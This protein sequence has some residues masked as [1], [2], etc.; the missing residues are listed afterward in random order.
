MSKS[1]FLLH[2]IQPVR[3]LRLL[4]LFI[5]L[6]MAM[7]ATA[8][9]AQ[10]WQPVPDIDLSKYSP[11]DFSDAEVDMPYFLK[12]FHTIANSVVQSGPA[13]GFINI[14]VWRAKKT[15]QTY[16]ARIMENVIALAYFYSTKRPWNPYY[17]SEPVR[18]RLE[19]AL[20]NLANSQS[21]QGHFAEYGQDKWNLSATAFYT[22][23]MGQTIKMIKD[24]PQITP[25]VLKRAIE[26][27]RK[28]I[29]L[30]LNDD[31][32]YQS[33]MVFANQYGNVWGGALAY[34]SMFPDKAME[35]QM[36]VRL[37]QAKEFQSPIGFF[38]EG[39]ATDFGYNLGTHQSDLWSAYQYSRGT[40]L[41]K[42]FVKE[43]DNFGEWIKY[44]AVPEPGTDI[45]TLNRGIETRQKAPVISDSFTFRSTPLSL[46][47]E[48]IRAFVFS[49][50]DIEKKAKKER[51]KLKT[52][53]PNVAPLK[54][55]YSMA[56]SPY[57]FLER[58]YF[59]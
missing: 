40:D 34:M 9:Y 43:E 20:E 22:K 48:S 5:F 58:D 21:P 45:Y 8:T 1:I 4:A 28:A 36:K 49:K 24:M 55:G 57:D 10:G 42:V 32:M 11:D 47:V 16:N 39:G 53:W 25:A 50:I 33:G 38:Y 44:N 2:Q 27:D 13:K 14:V 46:P 51:A 31:K 54:V 15:N 7:P 29:N 35:T 26:A 41:E 18:L 3:Q 52:N 30:I 19:A 6:Y 56:Y 59:T 12:H 23:F 17:G 37:E